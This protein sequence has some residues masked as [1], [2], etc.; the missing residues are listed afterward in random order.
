MSD[1]GRQ[2]AGKI[3]I[4]ILA[5]SVLGY[6]L[7]VAVGRL[8]TPAEYATFMTFWGLI[9]GLG[10]AL[11]PLEQELARL[12][13]VADV[14][15]RKPGMDTLRS[16]GVATVVVVLFGLVLLIPSVNQ[17]LF[18]DHYA[19][20]I[21]VLIGGIAFAAQFAMRG[22]LIGQNEISAYSWLLIVEAAVRPVAIGVLV[23]VSLIGMVP[24]AVAVALGSF[25]WLVFAP[26][27]GSRIDRATAGDSWGPAAKRVLFLLLGSALTASVITGYPAMIKL[28]APG[29]DED[30]LGSFFAA[31][32]LSRIPLLLFASV[33]AL[34]VPYVVR[35]SAS[36]GMARLRRMLVLGSF[37]AVVVGA[38]AAAIS[39]PVGP[40]LVQLLYTSK[41]AVSGWEVAGLMWSAVLLA[42]V[43][44]LVAVLVAEKRVTAVVVTWAATAVLTG[45]VLAFWPGEQVLRA[46]LG[47]AIGSV[48][49]LIVGLALVMRAAKPVA[50]QKTPVGQ[51]TSE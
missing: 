48:A 21:I 16:L 2:S 26:R 18:G 12:S 42:A 46:T 51:G 17:Q 30:K 31:L 9:F 15:G 14:D 47:L 1:G 8:L 10:S 25:A 50:D 7:T 33:Q 3:G 34:A 36:G 23:V 4:A 24:F 35:L 22:L 20:G 29:G 32:A 43:Q 28:L 5:G 37:G 19:L 41:Y 45:L 27:T 49:G 39:L 6:V 38:V 40:W 13:A 11:S 44:L